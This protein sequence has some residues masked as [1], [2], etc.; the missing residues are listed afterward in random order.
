MALL[1]QDALGMEPGEPGPGPTR[2][3]GPE[4]E[5]QEEPAGEVPDDDT[6]SGEV[7]SLFDGVV[8]YLRAIFR[9]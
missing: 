5:G 7:V 9:L 2:P 6:L 8:D 3:S 4:P 1:P